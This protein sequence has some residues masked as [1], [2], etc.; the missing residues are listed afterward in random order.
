MVQVKCLFCP[1]VVTWVS[2][3]ILS[4]EEGLETVAETSVEQHS[5]G[6]DSQALLP[7]EGGPRLPA[8]GAPCSG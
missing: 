2:Y 8:L 7:M 1:L 4:G 5:Q 3:S 6:W